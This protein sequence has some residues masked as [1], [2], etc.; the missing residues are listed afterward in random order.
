MRALLTTL[1]SLILLTGLASARIGETL[2]ECEARYGPIIERRPAELVGSDPEMVVF[3]KATV[4]V[5]V[6]FREGR[7]WHI[8][9]RKKSLTALEI[10]ALLKADSGDGEWSAP[11]TV[12]DR[13]FRLSADRQRL[14]SVSLA[15]GSFEL[16]L[17]EIMTRDFATQLHEQLASRAM[18]REAIEATKTRT[19][20]LPGF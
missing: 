18:T 4:T 15:K 9:Y 5:M 17:V 2:Q 12:A 11:L 19:N 13:D 14:A 16:G 6:E 3:S 7:A 1:A 20:P 8:V 10:E